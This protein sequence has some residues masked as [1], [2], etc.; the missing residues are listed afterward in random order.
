MG[1]SL[2]EISNFIRDKIGTIYGRASV[3]S[4]SMKVEPGKNIQKGQ[5]LL[6][7]G[8]N[9]KILAR[10]VDIETRMSETI[11]KCEI[12][13]EIQGDILVQ[14]IHPVRAGFEVYNPNGEFLSRI[15]TRT[16]AE[17]GL[18]I[19]K[20]LT[21]PDFVP[22]Y[23]NM[24]DLR[25]HVFVSATT[26]GGKSYTLSVIIEE[27]L[28]KIKQ[29]KDLS[30][31]VFDVHDEYSGFVDENHNPKQIA[32]LREF[33][34]EPQGFEDQVL[35]F[36]WENN[37]PY[38]SPV[39]S[40]DRL[41]FIFS[42]KELRLAFQLRQLM[43]K[44]ESMNIDDLIR[45]VEI[46]ELHFQ[47]KQALLTRMISL[48]DSGFLA[49]DYIQPEEFSIP[50][51]ITI[52]RLIGTPMGDL[53]IRFFVADIV[54]QVFEARKIGRIKHNVLLIVD[55]AHLFAPAK[56]KDD[57]VKEILI[58]VAREGRKLGVWLILATQTPRDL[59]NEIIMNCST[60]I[61][62]R[63]QRSDISRLAKLFGISSALVEVL[64]KTQPGECFIKAPSFTIPILVKIRPRQSSE[65]KGEGVDVEKLM[66]K[67]RT[68]AI[69]TREYILKQRKKH[70]VEKKPQ[71]RTKV[72]QPTLPS[73]T[74]ITPQ[75]AP[76]SN[77]TKPVQ[78]IPL[79]TQQ[80]STIRQQIQSRSPPHRLRS[81][82]AKI[83]FVATIFADQI[84]SYGSS[85]KDFIFELL[86]YEKMNLED[87]LNKIGEDLLDS[88]ILDGIIRIENN[89]V[90]LNLD[91]KLREVIGRKISD[92]HIR[93]AK[94]KLRDLLEQSF[95]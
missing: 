33:G 22:V 77:E 38:L 88:L 32:G 90:K 25:V 80:T 1:K 63:M 26:G 94:L 60:I 51:K 2:E 67:I 69:K 68:I 4:F 83:Y 34:L 28:K 91:K 17:N 58:R 66:E 21:H 75:H 20:I 27:L 73:D 42:M 8:Q 45:L 62:L 11:G 6:V 93:L 43:G 76:P 50:G 82:E 48:R 35:I 19:G 56:G 95:E 37:P 57:P 5:F 70:R 36:D 44:S 13:G 64:T 84:N 9:R 78:I 54:R 15:I 7:I 85:I 40:P 31:I 89:I 12:L 59:S 3:S 41:M 79:R 74:T 61:A 16:T 65:L 92:K 14:P 29:T 39:F 86:A 72:Q 87:A 81:T 23:Y 53:G 47:T 46:S 18:Y 49:D 71:K 55:E 30:I 52:F 24:K 10:V